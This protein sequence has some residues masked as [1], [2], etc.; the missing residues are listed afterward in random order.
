MQDYLAASR[1]QVRPLQQE[2]D[3]P[4]LRCPRPALM[5]ER[6]AVAGRSLG[7]DEAPCTW[8]RCRSVAVPG[9]MG[10]NRHFYGR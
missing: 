9:A 4:G 5:A 6:L 3:R 2:Q 8:P 10:H 7:P 1:I